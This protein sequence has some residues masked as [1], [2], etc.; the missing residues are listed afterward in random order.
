MSA[1]TRRRSPPILTFTPRTPEPLRIEVQRLGPAHEMSRMGLHGHRFFE[2]LFFERARGS[3][4]V[5]DATIPAASGDLVLL[6]PGEIH[7]AAGLRGL[8]GHLLLF[9]AD[10][11]EAGRSDADLFLLPRELALHAF[12]R[13]GADTRLRI[14]KRDRARWSQRLV[15]LGAELA[16]RRPGFE[17]AARSLLRLLL[18][19]AARLASGEHG[20]GAAH[21]PL[22]VDVFRFIESRFMRPISLADVAKAV[23]RSPAHLTDLVRRETGR[24]VLAWILERRMVEAR[25]LL[26]ETDQALDAVAEG[27]GFSDAGYF[28]RQFRR[29]HRMTPAAWRRGHR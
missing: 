20:V 10:A 28:I 19:D 13:R 25:R 8:A 7:D 21:R 11:L 6:P 1:R 12:L 23:S 15:E 29:H 17:D 24:P 26:L 9:H 2:I 18:V 16:T 5:G 22:L 27:C 14:P 3:H 4:R